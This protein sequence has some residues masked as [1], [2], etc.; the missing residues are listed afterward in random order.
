LLQC[1]CASG[2]LRASQ[3]RKV[4]PNSW[5]KPHPADTLEKAPIHHYL[6]TIS[7]YCHEI[8]TCYRRAVDRR[9]LS[10]AADGRC[11]IQKAAREGPANRGEQGR[12][13]NRRE[14]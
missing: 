3:L 5:K 13:E 6:S 11:A 1:T 12:A 7:G 10:D 8:P 4:A 9:N 14:G 2:S